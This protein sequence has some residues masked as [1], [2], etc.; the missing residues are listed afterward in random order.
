VWPL[1]V[2]ALLAG[3]AILLGAVRPRAWMGRAIA[4]AA[5]LWM[6]WSFHWTHYAT[7]N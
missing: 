5:W 6:A 2:L 1:H 7:V 4:V 3:V